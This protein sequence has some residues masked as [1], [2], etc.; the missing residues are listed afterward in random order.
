MIQVR[1]LTDL[2]FPARGHQAGDVVA[3]SE[4]QAE[5]LVRLELAEVAAE[6]DEA[7]PEA[8]TMAEAPE[9]AVMPRG[10]KRG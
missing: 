6:T 1:L 3:V 2:S 7:P 8:A 4:E 9:H 5:V 10:R